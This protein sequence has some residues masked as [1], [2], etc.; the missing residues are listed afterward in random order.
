[1]VFGHKYVLAMCEHNHPTIIKIH[2]LLIFE[3]PLNQVSLTRPAVL[4]LTAVWCHISEGGA[5]G[6]DW[7]SYIASTF[8]LSFIFSMLGQL[9]RQQLIVCI[10][11]FVYFWQVFSVVYNS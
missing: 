2:P 4:I 5:T 8:T 1:M 3:S 9:Q 10:Y 11:L 7:Q 6:F